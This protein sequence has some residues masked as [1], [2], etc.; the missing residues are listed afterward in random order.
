MSL[1]IEFL[2]F[3]NEKKYRIQ[4][5]PAN[6]IDDLLHSLVFFKLKSRVL[7]IHLREAAVLSCNLYQFSASRNIQEGSEQFSFKSMSKISR[8]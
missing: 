3:N 4:I 2:I 1:L 7:A 6:K 5:N 8:E